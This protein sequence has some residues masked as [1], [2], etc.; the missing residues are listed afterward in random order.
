MAKCGHLCLVLLLGYILCA[1][2]SVVRFGSGH[3]RLFSPDGSH[4]CYL[5]SQ[6]KKNHLLVFTTGRR[7]LASIEL[8]GSLAPSFVNRPMLSWLGD[9]EHLVVV[10]NKSREE[11]VSLSP[12]VKAYRTTYSADGVFLVDIPERKVTAV[13]RPHLDISG[14]TSLVDSDIIVYSASSEL[15]GTR[16]VSITVPDIERWEDFDKNPPLKKKAIRKPVQNVWALDL[17]TGKAREL[18]LGQKQVEKIVIGNGLPVK[19]AVVMVSYRGLFGSGCY[20][21][22]LDKS[23]RTL[24]RVS[25]ND[26]TLPLALSPDGSKLVCQSQWDV[27][28]YDLQSRTRKRLFGPAMMHPGKDAFR[29]VGGWVYFTGGSA[30]CRGTLFR[31]P[32]TDG[33]PT[34]VHPELEIGSDFNISPDGSML[35]FSTNRVLYFLNLAE[36]Q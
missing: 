21:S 22:T 9:G 25:N 26:F 15:G 32:I 8:P 28:L 3:N 6:E 36:Q 4:L 7:L 11:D 14:L 13:G 27:V 16:K 33:L 20:V 19:Q 5:R 12:N 29:L 10:L 31:S 24:N 34:G 17:R 18:R 35:A 30:R 23:L 1:G 2:Q